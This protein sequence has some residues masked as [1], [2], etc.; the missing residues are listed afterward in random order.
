[1]DVHKLI[2]L[3]HL[4]NFPQLLT[5]Q[6]LC[7]SQKES[8]ANLVTDYRPMNHTNVAHYCKVFGEPAERRAARLGGVFG[9]L[10][11]LTT[12]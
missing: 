10:P 6:I 4:G 11:E 8:N 2:R 1:M 5:I 7:S 9:S 12:P 3:L